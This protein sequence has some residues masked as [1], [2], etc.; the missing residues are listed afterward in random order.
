MEV[1]N[2]C[3]NPYEGNFQTLSA[4]LVTS[5]FLALLGRAQKMGEFHKHQPDLIL[6]QIQANVKGRPATM[7]YWIPEIST[8]LYALHASSGESV[9]AW[10]RAQLTV[11]GFFAGALESFSLELVEPVSPLYVAGRT[12]SASCLKIEAGK[13][14]LRV[15]DGQENQLLVVTP[16]RSDHRCLFVEEESSLLVLLKRKPAIRLATRDWNRQWGDED[17]ELGNFDQR[18]LDQFNSAFE[19]LQEHLPEYYAWVSQMTT[20]LTPIRR[21]AVNTIGSSSSDWRWGGLNIA[22]PASIS[23]TVEM[24]IHE[25]SH[26]YYYMLNAFGPM[27]SQDAGKYYSPLKK[28]QRPLDRILLGYHAFANASLAFEKLVEQGFGEL[29]EDRKECVDEY[30]QELLVPL[31]SEAGLAPMGLALYRPLREKIDHLFY[32]DRAASKKG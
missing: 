6:S 27:V 19:F 25:A 31:E 12:I 9:L 21:P 2:L 8:A 15:L 13:N 11:G 16:A 7:K 3:S 24:L 17:R 28:C 26:Q 29:I 4:Q 5:N 23:E 10:V 14:G 18:S 20:E 32:K 22:Q 1:F 30:M